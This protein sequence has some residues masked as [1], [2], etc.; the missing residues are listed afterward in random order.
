MVRVGSPFAMMYLYEAMEKAEL[1]DEIIQSIREKYLPM[2]DAGATT[3]WETFAGA[4]PMLDGPSRSHCHGWSAVPL[5]FF[6]RIILGIKQMSAGG[7]VIQISP[8]LNG[9]TWAEGISLTVNGVIK[10]AWR[11]TDKLLEI[12]YSVPKGTQ[13]KFVRNDTHKSMQVTENMSYN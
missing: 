4:R 1:N 7:K 6:N 8:R 3:V 5:Y 10:V 2:I 11:V 13:A 9:L 12:K